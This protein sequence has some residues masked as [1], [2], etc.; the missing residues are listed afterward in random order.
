MYVFVMKPMVNILQAR[1]RVQYKTDRYSGI[2]VNQ[3]VK[4]MTNSES[5]RAAKNIY[6]MTRTV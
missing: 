3:L 2:Q 5:T 1:N 6:K 4:I